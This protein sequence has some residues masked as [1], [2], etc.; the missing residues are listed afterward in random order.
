M[1]K[2]GIARRVDGGEILISAA[3]QN[4]QLFLSVANDGPGFSPG[5]EN[6]KGIGLENVRER[7]QSLYG[8]SAG[9]SVSTGDR[10]GAT[11]SLT[12]PY[13]ES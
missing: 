2:H 3:R 5:W 1:V 13:Q 9:L 8:D 7:L 12:L 11:V 10:A 6:K 4:G